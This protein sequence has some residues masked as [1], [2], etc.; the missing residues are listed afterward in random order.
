MVAKVVMLRGSHAIRAHH[1]R[2]HTPA[3]GLTTLARAIRESRFIIAD[4]SGSHPNILQDVHYAIGLGKRPILITQDAPEKT[5]FHRQGWTIY[6]YDLEDLDSLQNLLLQKVANLSRNVEDE[7]T[8]TPLYDAI[9]AKM[10]LRDIVPGRWKNP[11][12]DRWD[13]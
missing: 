3:S 5:V 9:S 7:V 10:V 4:L 12:A 1:A 2:A 6:Q 8:E 13:H 11:F